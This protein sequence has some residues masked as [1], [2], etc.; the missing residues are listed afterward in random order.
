M[1]SSQVEVGSRV[2]LVDRKGNPVLFHRL[3][4]IDVQQSIAEAG[5]SMLEIG[6]FLYL[7][8]VKVHRLLLLVCL[9]IGELYFVVGLF[10]V[11]VYID[12]LLV[13]TD[14]LFII[15]LLVVDIPFIQVFFVCLHIHP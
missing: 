14:C 5:V 1:N 13:T 8:A 11:R 6:V 2:G 15:F 4:L 10:A 7:R 9:F 12:C 3:G